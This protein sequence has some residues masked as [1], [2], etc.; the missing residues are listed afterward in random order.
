M[1]RYGKGIGLAEAGYAEEAEEEKGDQGSHRD[2]VLKFGLF[3][4]LRRSAF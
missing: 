2:S 1:I 3:F 4:L